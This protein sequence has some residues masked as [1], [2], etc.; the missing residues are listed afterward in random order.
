MK[1]FSRQ[2]FVGLLVG[3][4]TLGL[5]GGFVLGA[6]GKKSGTPGTVEVEKKT[7][8]Q[9]QFD[10][11]RCTVAIDVH[12]NAN[13]FRQELDSTSELIWSQDGS[14]TDSDLKVKTESN[15]Y[16]GYEVYVYASNTSPNPEKY[17]DFDVLDDFYVKVRSVDSSASNYSNNLEEW[18]GFDEIGSG[19]TNTL[20]Y[21]NE[22]DLV[23]SKNPLNSVNGTEWLMDYKYDM[24]NQ[25]VP[26]EEYFVE[27]TYIVSSQ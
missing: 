11:S 9:W 19:D 4:L 17:A 26:N 22:R 18:A 15:C 2:I 5:S 12:K 16:N 27:L 25:D 23:G 6:K 21:V 14:F 13:L 8:A 3:V 10:S 1:K 7:K 24:D 20:G